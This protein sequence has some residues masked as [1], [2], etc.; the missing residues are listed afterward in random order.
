[1]PEA[2][3]LLGAREAA[4]EQAQAEQGRAL[5]ARGAR[6]VLMKGGHGR[7]AEVVDL[8]V[9]ASETRAFR[10]KRL[11]TPHTHGTGC[12]LSAAVAAGLALGQGLAEA[13]DAAQAF[14]WNGLVSGRDLGV[15]RGHG[16]V[17]HLWAMRRG[18]VAG[19]HG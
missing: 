14:V 12:T 19:Q 3:R 6:A 1:L 7:S 10:R 4:D 8:L 18:A 13:V 9:T 11:D 5:L 2:A 16:P 15:G 17:D